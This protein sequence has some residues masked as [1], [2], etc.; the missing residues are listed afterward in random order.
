M[1]I[2]RAK[3]TFGT[4]RQFEV[5]SSQ[6]EVEERYQPFRRRFCGKRM[7]EIAVVGHRTGLLVAGVGVMLPFGI[8]KIPQV[9]EK[10]NL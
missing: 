6:F 3:C 1:A 8:I 5:H 9:W 4:I 7:F 10:S 2:P